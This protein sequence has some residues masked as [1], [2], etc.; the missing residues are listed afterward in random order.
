MSHGFLVTA[1]AGGTAVPQLPA[2]PVRL[3]MQMSACTLWKVPA[4]LRS[5]LGT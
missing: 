1:Q 5:Y 2:A 4:L 3:R